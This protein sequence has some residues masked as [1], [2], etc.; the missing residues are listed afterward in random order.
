MKTITKIKQ[1]LRVSDSI[2]NNLT[3]L[4]TVDL[5]NEKIIV[6]LII[7]IESDMAT[8]QFCDFM[9][10]LVEGLQSKGVIEMLRN[11]NSHK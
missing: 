7:G 11:G 10:I 1:Q 8:L 5:I 9:E 6:F 4:P 3:N 2:L